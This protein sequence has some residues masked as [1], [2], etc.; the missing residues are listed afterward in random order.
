MNTNTKQAKRSVYL[1][2]LAVNDLSLK[3]ARVF[4]DKIVHYRASILGADLGLNARKKVTEFIKNA[5]GEETEVVFLDKPHEKLKVSAHPLNVKNVSDQLLDGY[6]KLRKALKKRKIHALLDQYQDYTSFWDRLSDKFNYYY[7]EFLIKVFG[8]YRYYEAKA[9]KSIAAVRFISYAYEERDEEQAFEALLNDLRILYRL[10][11]IRGTLAMPSTL[12]LADTVGAGQ[13]RRV[14]F[15]FLSIDEQKL[16]D[17]VG[18][19]NPLE[20][21]RIALHEILIGG[22]SREGEIGQWINGNP[23]EKYKI[24]TI[25]VYQHESDNSRKA[26]I[27]AYLEGLDTINKVS[28]VVKE[29]LN[30]IQ[31]NESDT[32]T[33]GEMQK[34]PLGGGGSM[35]RAKEI[36]I[37]MNL[38][39]KPKKN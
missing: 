27:D 1:K 26:H 38:S 28:K 35:F 32:V 12:N 37:S 31:K 24:E 11:L 23:E 6:P 5:E 8:K 25:D 18:K 4:E 34:N 17:L 10:G 15:C 3:Y 14:V 19:P 13:E 21:G 36:H 2:P 20:H 30:S 22:E 39:Q 7:G 9:I 16:R 33:V 29:S